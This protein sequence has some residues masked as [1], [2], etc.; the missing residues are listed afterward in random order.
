MVFYIDSL[1]I[2]G[3]PWLARKARKRHASSKL[4]NIFECN[5]CN[6]NYK[7]KHI[8]QVHIK[9][10]HGIKWFQCPKYASVFSRKSHLQTHIDR[11]HDKKMYRCSKCDKPYNQ[12][13][14][15]MRHIK[16]AKNCKGATVI[17]FE[18]ADNTVLGS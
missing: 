16:N 11:K 3:I 7:T 15:V 14:S 6:E 13:P 5:H 10:V 1:H 17:V 8:L 4:G 9:Y 18:E 12:P 2:S